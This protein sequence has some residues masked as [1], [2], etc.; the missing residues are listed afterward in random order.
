[1]MTRVE[2]WRV[3]MHEA[4]HAVAARS[5]NTWDCKASATIRADGGG[6]AAVLP[7]G[8]SAFDCAVAVA[9]GGHAEALGFDAPK[10]RRRT[11]MPQGFTVESVRSR[12]G[13]DVQS[14]AAVKMHH[15]A[16]ASG[17]DGERIAMYCVSLHPSEPDEWVAAHGR[18]HVE[19]RRV[20]W[21]LR[22][23]IKRVALTLF[24]RAR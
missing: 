4:A 15:E 21:L 24:H 16:M 20:V 3:C 5:L 6:G 22:H 2:R 13:R 7:A 14:A 9:A 18:I 23:E 1:M 19:A 11:A 8:L 12:A 17:T 10:R